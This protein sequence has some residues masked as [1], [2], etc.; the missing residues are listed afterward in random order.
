MPT[1]VALVKHVPDTWSKKTLNADATLNRADADEVIDEI[2]E[3]SVEQALRIR[4]ANPDV[5]VKV[6]ALTMGTPRAEEALRKALAM[7]VD[8]AVLLSDDA[9]AGC[10][11]MGT[12]WALHNAIA[13]ID[14]CIAVVAGNTSSDGAMGMV[15]GILAEYRQC[16]AVTNVSALQVDV[17]AATVT[18]TRID[19]SGTSELSCALPVVVSVS[20]R[21]DKPRFPN[22]K[23]IMA[24][25]KAPIKRLGLSDIGVLPEQVG[26]TH[27]ATVVQS[28]VVRPKRTQ[29]EIIRD[30]GDGG[31]AIARYLN[32]QALL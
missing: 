27:S 8:E 21:C 19:A 2:N 17:A 18:A 4:E 23:G 1:I 31:K 13:T 12:A 16:P 14:E 9:L 29:G 25:K 24:A 26:L 28:T 11:V 5:G 22:F 7:G 6:V 30:N 20:E 32:S 3:Y 10:D 15:P